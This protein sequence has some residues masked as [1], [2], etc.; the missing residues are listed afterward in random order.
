MSYKWT[1]HKPSARCNTARPGRATAVEVRYGNPALVTPPRRPRLS[2]GSHPVDNA[3]MARK[4][5]VD[6]ITDR[7]LDRIIEGAYPPGSALPTEMML[8][9]EFDVSRVTVRAATKALAA[10]GI[11][12]T[13]RGVGSTVCALNRWT[14]ITALLRA[15]GAISDDSEAAIQLVQLRRMLECGAAE[16]AAKH[17]TERELRRLDELVDAMT[18]SHERSDIELY[19]EADLSFHEAILEASRNPFISIG[20]APLTPA[21]AT[22]RHLTSSITQMRIDGIAHHHTIIA[23]LAA[24]DP[25]ASRKAMDLHMQ[26]TVDGIRHHSGKEP[27]SVDQWPQV[28][29]GRAGAASRSL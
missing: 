9:S 28:R 14:S 29:D 27:R 13:D 8:A 12:R 20:F 6:E 19:V 2:L 21:L 26:Q 24:R 3:H 11:V 1:V 23:A 16:L 15:A 5:L 22:H 10:Q 17:I 7:L 25:E 4:L 18:K